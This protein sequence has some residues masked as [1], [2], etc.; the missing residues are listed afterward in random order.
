[1][2]KKNTASDALQ[3]VMMTLYLM[4]VFFGGWGAYNHFFRVKDAREDRT[5]ERAGLIQIQDMLAEDENK[6]ALIQWRKRQES[7]NRGEDNLLQS[8]VLEVV[9]GLPR[10]PE[11]GSISG[12]KPSSRAGVTELQ[13][14]VTFKPTSLQRGLLQFVQV[15]EASKPHISFERVV[16]N[17]RNR[18]RS[19]GDDNWHAEFKLVTYTSE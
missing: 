15:L 13:C 2:A 19:E 5:R 9:Q 3:I 16:I 10:K 7:K 11:I 18:R 14:D 4:A 12:S 6:E 17:Q 1:M 8:E